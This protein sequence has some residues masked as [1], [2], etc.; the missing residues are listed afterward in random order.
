M[1]WPLISY[2]NEGVKVVFEGA[3]LVRK[4]LPV[5]DKAQHQ[6]DVLHSRE[7]RV[8]GTLL[9]WNATSK[10]IRRGLRNTP[11]A[12]ERGRFRGPDTHVV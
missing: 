5:R 10:F 12:T 8:V 2:P 1:L 7:E 11:G 9:R 6:F 4:A 3:S